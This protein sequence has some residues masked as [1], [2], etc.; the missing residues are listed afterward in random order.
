MTES[1]VTVTELPGSGATREQLAMLYTRYHFAATHCAGK[2]VLEVACGP[3]I[4]LGYLERSARVVVGGDYDEV[5][6]R[7]ACAYYRD[8][9]RLLRLD[10][11]VLPF[12]SQS[13]DVVLLFEALYYLRDPDRFVREARRVLRAEGTLLISTV[14]REWA[15][16]NPSPF[17]HRYLSAAELKLMLGE[18]G[19]SV[20]LYGAFPAQAA[21]A[22]DSLLSAAR[23][24]AVRLRLIPRSMK[25][26]QVLKRLIYGRLTPL[27]AEARDGMA[28]LSPL[29]EVS[30]Q[31][32]TTAF[33]VLYALGRT[34]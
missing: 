6:L 19:F 15:D 2:D 29:A 14:N 21:S 24:T 25:G 16:F 22:R 34:P 7:H 9:A 32:A 4:G 18:H 11:Q 17:T 31:G 33:K 5:M 10:A 8:R 27:P 28:E 30:G 1:Y 3:G 20:E 12:A 23:R 26:K 13:F